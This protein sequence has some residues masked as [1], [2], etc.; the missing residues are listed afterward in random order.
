[1][2]PHQRSRALQEIRDRTPLEQ[3]RI[4]EGLWHVKEIAREI[5][6]DLGPLVQSFYELACA[7]IQERAIRRA[8]SEPPPSRRRRYAEHE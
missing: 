8:Q 6:V 2:T 7:A 5:G 1:M 4:E 3:R